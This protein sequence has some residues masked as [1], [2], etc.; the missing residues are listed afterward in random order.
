MRVEFRDQSMIIR[1]FRDDHITNCLQQGTFY[2]VELLTYLLQRYGT[3]GCYVDF[4]AFIGNHSIFFSRVCKADLVIA[5]EPSLRSF[6][7][8]SHNLQINK[9]SNVQTYNMA[10]GDRDCLCRIKSSDARNRGQTEIKADNS[11]SIKMKSGDSVIFPNAPK[12]IKI[13]TEGWSL[14]V[15]QGCVQ[16]IAKY[17]PVLVVETSPD[18][19]EIVQEFLS[20]YHYSLKGQFNATPTCV[21]E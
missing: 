19:V 11:G 16:T 18:P 6:D 7:V 14:A 8:L 1:G 4:G 2:E 9:V 21:F 5:V 15:L 17:H 10:V 13:D 20:T 12:L 3:G